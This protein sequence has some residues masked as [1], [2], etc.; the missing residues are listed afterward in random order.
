MT[1]NEQEWT[2]IFTGPG[3]T[4][5]AKFAENVRVNLDRDLPE[6]VAAV[7][8]PTKIPRDYAGLKVVRSWL[9]NTAN[10]GPDGVDEVDDLTEFIQHPGD[11][12]DTQ[13]C[14][15]VLWGEEGDAE[16]EALVRLATDLG[17]PVKDLTA[18]MD[19]VIF[20]DTPPAEPEPETPKRTRRTR[21]ASADNIVPPKEDPK[22]TPPGVP[23][24]PTRRG[25]PRAANVTG[26]V[27]PEDTNPEPPFVVDPGEQVAKATQAGVDAA[28][29]VKPSTVR[30]TDELVAEL[31][32][33]VDARVA[34]LFADFAKSLVPSSPGRPRR[35]GTPA[36]PKTE[37]EQ[38]ALVCNADGTYSRR[39]RGR[40]DPTATIVYVD[41]DEV[42]EYLAR[43]A[44]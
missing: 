3:G 13:L 36:Q 15:V 39:G 2:Y 20:E 41:P 44:G 43:E 4:E 32:A 34:Q 23:S 12:A 31:E 5:D 7:V 40:P 10:F 19:D 9:T 37:A 25:K 33:F 6:H 35:D 26:P 14:L 24:P 29:A 38:V 16:T 17:I 22:E 30:V 28:K 18:G 1:D 11:L 42:D 8:L 27:V 21:G